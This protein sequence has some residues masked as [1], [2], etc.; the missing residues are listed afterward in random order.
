MHRPTPPMLDRYDMAVEEA[1]GTCDRNLHGAVKALI[2]A[3]EY[4]EKNLRKRSE[5]GR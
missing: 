3:N 5:F 4:L 1:I 2:I